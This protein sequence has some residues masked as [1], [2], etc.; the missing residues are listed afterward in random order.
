MIGNDIWEDLDIDSMHLQS[1]VNHMAVDLINQYG[2]HL[3]QTDILNMK[4]I[5]GT[6]GDPLKRALAAAC[7]SYY[8]SIGYTPKDRPLNETPSNKAWW[9]LW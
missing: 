2:V 5:E 7:L 8:T 3:T 1:E 9:K 6:D 4:S